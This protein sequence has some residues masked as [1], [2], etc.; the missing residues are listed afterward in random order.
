MFYCS[1]AY[2]IVHCGVLKEVK[3]TEHKLTMTGT[4]NHYHYNEFIPNNSV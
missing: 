3:T 4:P 1:A 2:E